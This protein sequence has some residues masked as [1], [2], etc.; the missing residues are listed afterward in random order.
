MKSKLKLPCMIPSNLPNTSFCN[1]G[2]ESAEKLSQCCCCLYMLLQGS[3]ETSCSSWENTDR[4]AKGKIHKLE[5]CFAVWGITCRVH[6]AGLTASPGVIPSSHQCCEKW[7]FCM[8]LSRMLGLTFPFRCSWMEKERAWPNWME[9][10]PGMQHCWL[11]SWA[12]GW[13][14]AQFN[15]CLLSPQPPGHTLFWQSIWIYCTTSRCRQLSLLGCLSKVATHLALSTPCPKGYW[16]SV[17]LIALQQWW[18]S[19]YSE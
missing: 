18:M 13:A 15:H 14:G 17:L 5:H 9:G 1:M 3:T 19:S 8:P 6:A 4:Q 16:C 7:E 12:E 11:E 2:S 10:P